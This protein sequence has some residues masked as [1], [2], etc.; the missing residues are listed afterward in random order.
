M[1]SDTRAER[2]DTHVVVRA[3]TDVNMTDTENFTTD[4]RVV[5]DTEELQQEEIAMDN[6][7]WHNFIQSCQ[8]KRNMKK[9]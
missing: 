2:D 3:A 7:D 6:R 9:T 8:E 4:S 5:A 1:E